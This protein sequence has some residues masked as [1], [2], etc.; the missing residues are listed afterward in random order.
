MENKK[1]KKVLK[2]VL[3][4]V[5]GIVV[6]CAGYVGYYTASY[7]RIGD[8]KLNVEQGDSQS[9]LFTSTRYS[10]LS[11]NVGFGAY[12]DDYS[13]FMD[14]GKHSRAL[15]EDAVRK[16]LNGVIKTLSD[17]SAPYGVSNEFRFICFQE[18]D[19][20][21]TRSYGVSERNILRNAYS[22]YWSTY[23]QNYNSPYLLYPLFSP[24]GAN[25]SGMLTLS[26][27]KI[28]SANRVELPVESGFA[29]YADLDRCLSI[30]RVP[31]SGGKTLV[32]I[33]LHLTAYSS[34]GKIVNDQLKLLLDICK[35]EIEAGNYVICAGDFNQDLYGNSSEIFGVDGKDFSWAQPFDK[36]ILEGTSMQL[37]IPGSDDEEKVPS[38][39]NADAP[40]EK[41]KT[42]V[43][44][45]DGFLVSSNIIVDES[46][47]IDAG[48]KYSDHNPVCIRFGLA[49]K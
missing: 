38:C 19:Y 36:S 34:K 25:K 48:F 39:R 3:C 40:Y 23:A 5:L 43:L 24:H 41:G 2:I 15:S 12:S 4:V 29:K 44:T 11:W 32:L 16:N 47:V 18:V 7:K 1:A 17:N 6:L 26:K 20:E 31:V 13:F 37:V 28:D 30:N 49:S 33:N 10:L 9:G 8:K 42:F 45:V 46:H 14:G 27:Y 22:Q 35:T 21:S